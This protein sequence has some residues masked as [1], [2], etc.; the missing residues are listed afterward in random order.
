M[1]K[2]VILI[3][4]LVTALAPTVTFADSDLT[5]SGTNWGGGI[6]DGTYTYQG[7]SDCAPYG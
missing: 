3:A 1:K 6:G 7:N 2:I 4:L 5:V